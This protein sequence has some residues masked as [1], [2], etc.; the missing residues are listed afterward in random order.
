MFLLSK[1]GNSKR[2]T[3]RDVI[4]CCSTSINLAV[5]WRVG[6]ELVYIMMTPHV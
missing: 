3:V 2:S 6:T 4:H 1:E 5:V